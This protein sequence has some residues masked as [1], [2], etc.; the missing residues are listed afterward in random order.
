MENQM[1]Q[2][3]RNGMDMRR[4]VNLFYLLVCGYAACTTVFTRHSFGVET[5]GMN[6]VAALGLMLGY[7]CFTGSPAMVPF[8]AIWFIALAVQRLIT[9]VRSQRGWY[10]HSRYEGYPWL[11]FM[12]PFVQRV[13]GA[14]FCEM[15]FCLMAGAVL[16]GIDEALGRFVLFGFFSLI[17]KA[18]IESQIEQNK[19]QR[20]R[21]A[22]IEM[23][24]LTN[25]F[26]RR[27]Y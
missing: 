12:A 23:R 25:R 27:D 3:Q 18:A 20:M 10:E 14:K 1:R 6:G 22:E 8:L 15:M 2:Q 19:L 11:G 17:A 7:I 13:E 21:D 24:N 16:L 5:L 9:F 4:S 26:K